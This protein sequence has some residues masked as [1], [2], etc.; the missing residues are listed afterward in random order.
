MRIKFYTTL[1]FLMFIVL[2]AGCKSAAKV[3]NS[4]NYDEAVNLAVKKLQKKPGDAETMAL[5]QDAYR[6]AVNDHE[7]RIRQLSNN[8]NDLKWEWVYNEYASLQRLYHAIQSS[9]EVR[10]VIQATDYSSYINTY[11]ERAADVRYQRGMTMMEKNDRTSFKN[12]Y[13]EFNTALNFRPGDL[14]ISD[15]RDEAYELAVINV[16]VMPFDNYQYRYSS[17]NSDNNNNIETDLLRILKYNTGSNFVKIYSSWEAQNKKIRPDQIIDLQFT[18]INIGRTRDEKKSR[19][20]SKDVVVK[21]TVYRP[22]SIV[23]E[24]KKVTAKI[25]TT[26]RTLYS[27]GNLMVTVRSADGRRLWGDN[28]RGDH[29]WVTEFT[30]YTGDER[31]LSSSDK[32][33]LKR[34]PGTPPRE[35]EIIRQIINEINNRLS[36][37]IR[38][39]FN[40]F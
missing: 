12:A 18:T 29:S 14:M 10:S 39:Y 9:P 15:K 7:T 26:K 22:D 31:A 33:Q 16:V 20:V 38:N 21:E 2:M 30:T 1:Y 13:N 3:Y 34:Q 19:Q 11:A 5:L 28:I 35:D 8:N 4:G 24:Y 37:S 32:E 23:K 6:Y 25:T 36:S 17:Y 27:E 40:R